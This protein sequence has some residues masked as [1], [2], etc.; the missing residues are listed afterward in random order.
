[1]SLPPWADDDLE[2]GMSFDLGFTE[3]APADGCIMCSQC[4]AACPTYQETG[5]LDFSPMGRIRVMR[6]LVEHEQSVSDHQLEQLGSCL[7][8][9]RC[10]A[11]CPSQVQFTQLLTQNLAE[12]RH[13]R[14]VDRLVALMQWMVMHPGWL[15]LSCRLA[16]VYQK[17]GMQALLRKFGLIKRLGLLELD[18]MIRPSDRLISLQEHYP[19]TV[20]EIAKVALF[21]GCVTSEFDGSLVTD[22]IL[23]L[24][25]LGV[26]VWV[27][28]AQDCCGALYRHHGQMQQATELAQRNLSAFAMQP[29]DAIISLASGCGTC[30][31]DYGGWF[32]DQTGDMAGQ[33][34]DSAMDISAYI[35]QLNWPADLQ[36]QPLKTTVAV[37]T[38]CTFSNHA[39]ANS[40]V[41]KLLR[42][43]PELEPVVVTG[44]GCCGAGG[45]QML[46]HRVLA[47]SL[48]DNLLN[49]IDQNDAQ[50]LVTSNIG[51]LLHLS[52]GLQQRNLAIEVMHPVQ[53]I[54]RQLKN[55]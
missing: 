25:R 24:N 19:A 5:D 7:Q 20:T 33:F 16:T 36:P 2:K 6:E 53:L 55:L 45:T 43:I 23:L 35:D 29:V 13:Q 54:V 26:S 9:Q 21:T 18:A 41:L 12:L 44:K 1:M 32:E 34:S 11:A 3:N 30:L 17:T 15:R 40:V 50:I 48:S 38:P 51:C 46:T 49:E 10:E 37:H 39:D 31:K 8:C 4:L 14:P 47:K 28:P 22:S 27:P 42:Q 52:S